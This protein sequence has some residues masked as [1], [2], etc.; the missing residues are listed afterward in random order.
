MNT[1]TPLPDVMVAPNGARRG[2]TDHSALPITD[3][4]VIE[5][6][7]SCHAAGAGGIHIHIRDSD[8]EHLLDAA[9]YRALLTR[10]NDVVPN[11]Y[12]Q[13]TSEAAGRYDTATQQAMVRDLKPE[14]VSV[15]LRE[16]VRRDA[17]WPVATE[18]YAWALDADVAIQH[19]LYSPAELTTFLKAAASGRI[20]GAHFQLQFVLGTYDA[21]EVSIPANLSGFLGLLNEAPVQLTFDWMLCAFGKE[22]TECLVHALK[23]GGKARV[24][25]ENS[26]WNADGTLAKDNAA[27]VREVIGAAHRP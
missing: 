26:L 23:N 2:K 20:P 3:D 12:L 18:F 27:R 17:D 6:A 21:S 1:Y 15:A 4:E 19:I 9:R 13:I 14:H 5:T 22:E 11:M 24:G 8:G 16:M 10:L 25:F 7:I